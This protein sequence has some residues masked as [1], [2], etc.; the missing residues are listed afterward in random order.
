MKKCPYCAVEILDEAIVCHFCNR[1]LVDNV[2][3]IAVKRKLKDKNSLIELS[4]DEIGKLFHKW[5]ESYHSFPPTMKENVWSAINEMMTNDVIQIFTGFL[6][7]NI[8]DDNEFQKEML[9]V[10]TTANLWGCLCFAIGIESGLGRISE[11]E[12]PYYFF[13]VSK[14]F[15]NYLVGWILVLRETGKINNEKVNILVEL[16]DNSIDKYTVRLVS[17]GIFSGKEMISQESDLRF[18]NAL[19]EIRSDFP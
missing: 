14:F 12:V 4:L 19:N 16:I 8:F 15:R 3:Q 17:L 9:L 13:P 7:H 2:E 18:Y 5:S 1:N 10:F 6:E 11:K